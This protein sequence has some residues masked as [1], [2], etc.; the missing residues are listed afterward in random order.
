[1]MK[2][3]EL[4]R[5]YNHFRAGKKEELVNTKGIRGHLVEA[6]VVKLHEEK[7]DGSWFSYFLMCHKEPNCDD[8]VLRVL[9]RMSNDFTSSKDEPTECLRLCLPT[10][11]ATIAV[12]PRTEG[13][14]VVALVMQKV[15]EFGYPDVSKK[16]TA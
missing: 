11:G 5:V 15:A 9:M 1:M 13:F 4:Q 2:C 14:A 6:R 8:V 12:N 10:G 16:L 3:A 7:D